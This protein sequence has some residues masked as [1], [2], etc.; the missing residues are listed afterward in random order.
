MALVRVHRAVINK[1]PLFLSKIFSDSMNSESVRYPKLAKGEDFLPSGLEQDLYHTEVVA[2]SSS[3]HI[4][5]DF[6]VLV[7]IVRFMY[8]GKVELNKHKHYAPTIATAL[9]SASESYHLFPLQSLSIEWLRLHAS[10][11]VFYAL[12]FGLNAK[13]IQDTTNYEEALSLLSDIFNRFPEQII[14][15]EGFPY[16]S[17]GSLR[18]IIPRFPSAKH[19]V[20]RELIYRWNAHDGHPICEVK[21]LE[22]L[23]SSPTSYPDS[24]EYS[25]P[26]SADLKTV[27]VIVNCPKPSWHIQVGVSP[28]YLFDITPTI[29]AC[30][31]RVRHPESSEESFMT[32][33][34]TNRIEFCLHF[35]FKGN[36]VKMDM[37]S[38]STVISSLECDVD[39]LASQ[40]FVKSIMSTFTV[41]PL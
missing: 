23:L 36:H 10:V 18:E 26:I 33:I 30:I 15:D 22:N 39:Q 24:P 20:F 4:D 7:E 3:A 35:S 2:S 21:F 1:F 8:T 38:G 28:G 32:S 41:I 12:D 16:V 34:H 13:Y 5:L 25:R 29:H 6:R 17:F 37:Y 19:P 27:R 31:N 40:F 11:E 14:T 9:V